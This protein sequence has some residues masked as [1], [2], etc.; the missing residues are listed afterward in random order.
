M[1]IHAVRTV[2]RA[3]H[4]G[5]TEIVDADLSKYVGVLHGHTSGRNAAE[6]TKPSAG[7]SLAPGFQ[8]RF[9]FSLAFGGILS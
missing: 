5:H 8:V 3:I 9:L 6:S 7:R 1:H 4:E 2:E